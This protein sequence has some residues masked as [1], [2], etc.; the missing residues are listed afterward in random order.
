MNSSIASIEGRETWV[1]SSWT[2]VEIELLSTPSSRKLFCSER[3][4]CTLTPPVRPAAVPPL[5][6][7][8]RSPWTPGTSTIRSSQLRIASGSRDTALW[9]I[10]EPTAACV[11]SSRRVASAT[12]TASLTPP[13]ISEKS[14][15]ARWPASRITAR[16]W[17]QKPWASAATV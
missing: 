7:V 17:V 5:S 13:T 10:T 4:P 2:L 14:I 9:S 1:V 6:S 16:D 11:V 8:K 15:R 3:L 12:V